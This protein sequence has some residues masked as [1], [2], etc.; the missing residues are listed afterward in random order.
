[1]DD[2]DADWLIDGRFRLRQLITMTMDAE[3]AMSPF[4]TWLQSDT[5][6]VSNNKYCD[7]SPRR[8][9]ESGRHVAPLNSLAAIDR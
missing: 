9:E 3:T 4:A 8:P 1:V 7:S 6:V 5:V 2:W